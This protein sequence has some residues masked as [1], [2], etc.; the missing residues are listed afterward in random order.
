MDRSEPAPD[1]PA[2]GRARSRDV[3]H[4][5]PRRAPLALRVHAGE[6]HGHH[7]AHQPG[8]SGRHG[9]GAAALR[10]PRAA[11]AARRS[12]ER[13]TGAR[14]GLDHVRD[15]DPSPCPHREGPHP[16]APLL[17]GGVRSRGA[18]LLAP[19]RALLHELGRGSGHPRGSSQRRATGSIRRW[20]ATVARADGRRSR[21]RGQALGTGAAHRT[22][23]RRGERPGRRLPRERASRDRRDPADAR[24]PYRLRPGPVRDPGPAHATRPGGLGDQVQRRVRRAVLAGL[25]S[26]R[27]GDGRRGSREGGVRQLTA[28]GLAGHLARVPRR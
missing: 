18:G 10:S 3:R 13:A 20:I 19:A 6:V 12:V 5:R 9:P 25:G 21:G 14:V 27:P 17:R 2:R 28:V 15:V 8:R 22:A 24:G 16:A 23:R 4:L 1:R 11:G 7:S 26:H